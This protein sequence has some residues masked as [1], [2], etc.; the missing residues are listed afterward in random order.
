MFIHSRHSPATGIHISFLLFAAILAPAA[1]HAQDIDVKLFDPVPSPH[2][3]LGVHTSRPMTHMTLWAGL[4]TSYANDLL[5]GHRGDD[6]IM[7]PVAHRVVGELALSVGLFGWVDAGF[8]LPVFLRQVG[9]DYPLLGED[10]G[11]TGLGDLRLVVKGQVL[12]NRRFSGFGLALVAELGMPTGEADAFMRSKTATFTPRLVL[13]YRHPKG[14]TVA[15]NLGARIRSR[16]TVE[17]LAVGSEIRLGLGA[18][19]PLGLRGLWVVGEIVAALGL[20]RQSVADVARVTT[21][22]SPLE[23]LLALRWRYGAGL[24]ITAGA[25]VGL[26]DG[27]GAPDLRALVAVGYAFGLA[28]GNRLTPIPDPIATEPTN[29]GTAG[30]GPSVAGHR[31]SPFRR[32]TPKPPARVGP[33]RITDADFDKAAARDPDPDADGLPNSLDKC[34][35]KAEDMDG[36]QDGDGCP[37]PDNDRDG[38]PDEHDKCPLKPETVNGVKDD[39]GCPDKGTAQVILTGSKLKI[40][41]RIYFHTGSDQLKPSAFPILRQV[42]AFLKA[43]WRVRRILIEG[44]TDSRGDKE[45]NVDLSVRRAYRVRAFLVARGVGSERLVARGFGPKVPVASNR[46]A[47]GRAKNRRVVFSVKLVVKNRGGK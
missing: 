3:I 37:E 41:Q 10:S 24:V 22:T 40:S 35:N 9:E 28:R 38:I 13:D 34:P 43:H 21:R 26:T 14:Y 6:R 11:R 7:R 42:A 25:G 12:K 17:D 4:T 32:I 31:R 30:T 16:Q 39:D 1:A 47:R 23:A 8:S 29:K 15:L 19:A 46:N 36:F 5:V 33:R 2:A 44:H 18:E 45:K 27:Y 20:A